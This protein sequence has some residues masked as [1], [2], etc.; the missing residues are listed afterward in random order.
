MRGTVLGWLLGI[1]LTASLVGFPQVWAERPNAGPA[2]RLSTDSLTAL[3]FDLGDGRQQVTLIDP[4]TRAIAVYHVDRG[5]GVITLRSVR[6]AHWDLQMDEF[7][8]SS[9]TPREI[10]ALAER[11]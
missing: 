9:P 5:T 3:G 4:R 7:N 2:E 6:Q 1:G 8:S 11:R 10:R